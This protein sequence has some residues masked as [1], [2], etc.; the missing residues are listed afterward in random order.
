MR[1]RR[2]KKSQIIKEGREEKERNIEGDQGRRKQG[3]ES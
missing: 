1:R 3:K 2:G